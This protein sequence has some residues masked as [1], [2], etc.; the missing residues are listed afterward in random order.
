MPKSRKRA[1]TLP[2][3]WIYDS[4]KHPRFFDL[5][6]GN[7]PMVPIITIAATRIRHGQSQRAWQRLWHSNNKINNNMKTKYKDSSLKTITISSHP[8]RRSQHTRIR[9]QQMGPNKRKSLKDYHLTLLHKEKKIIP[10]S[11]YQRRSRGILG[12]PPKTL[13][14]SVA[15]YSF[16][17]R[18]F[19][20]Y[21][22]RSSEGMVIGAEWKLKQWRCTTT[23]HD[24]T[25]S[26]VTG[27]MLL[28]DCRR[29]PKGSRSLSIY[30]V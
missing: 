30:I 26:S 24:Q 3:G 27:E 17:S 9:L 4:R 13:D 15:I 1:T 2:F 14:R 20:K 19:D 11:S 29:T 28:N 10:F 6:Y 23:M 7:L 5:A 12:R 8:Y 16:F 21:F 25:T 18:S 22:M